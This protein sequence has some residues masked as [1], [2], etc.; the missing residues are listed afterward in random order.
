MGITQLNNAQKLLSGPYTSLRV[1]RIAYIQHIM[2]KLCAAAYQ[3]SN[4]NYTRTRVFTIIVE[5]NKAFERYEAHIVKN[6]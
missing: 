6:V 5:Q 3:E 1:H 4:Y 2:Y